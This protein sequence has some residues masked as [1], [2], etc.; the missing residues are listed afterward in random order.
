MLFPLPVRAQQ[1]PLGISVCL[2]QR[3]AACADLAWTSLNA[4]RKSY[5]GLTRS[6]QL[7]Q[8]WNPMFYESASWINLATI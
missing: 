7:S 3:Q 4:N 2:P 5:I 1:M 6:T 8:L